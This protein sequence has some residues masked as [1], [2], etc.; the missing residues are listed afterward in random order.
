LKKIADILNAEG[1]T[2]RKGKP[3]HPMQIK[4]ILDRKKIYEG[5]Y[6]YSGVEA[7]G[8]HQAIIYPTRPPQ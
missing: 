7:E 4:P 2:T 3:F 8:Q 5:R 6:K 1:F